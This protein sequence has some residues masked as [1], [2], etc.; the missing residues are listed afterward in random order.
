MTETAFLE[1]VWS[2]YIKSRKASIWAVNLE[3]NEGYLALKKT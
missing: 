3:E 1:L 2:Y